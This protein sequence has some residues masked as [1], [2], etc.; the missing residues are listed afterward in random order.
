MQSVLEGNS[1]ISFAALISCCCTVVSLSASQTNLHHVSVHA[2]I[3]ACLLTQVCHLSTSIRLHLSSTKLLP[4]DWCT[5]VLPWR[6]LS[7]WSCR[8]GSWIQQWRTARHWKGVFLV[9]AYAWAS[10]KHGTPITCWHDD[11]TGTGEEI[12]V[13]ERWGSLGWYPLIVLWGRATIDC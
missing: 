3:R 13:R 6:H 7:A 1:E 9:V 5:P 8:A 4:G 10:L 11:D 12:N 2:Y